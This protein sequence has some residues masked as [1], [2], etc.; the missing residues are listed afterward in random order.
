MSMIGEW[1]DSGNLYLIEASII[2]ATHNTS[3]GPFQSA[4]FVHPSLSLSNAHLSAAGPSRLNISQ[5]GPSSAGRSGGSTTI[6][7]NTLNPTFGGR[8]PTHTT[9]E[10]HVDVN[11]EV[12]DVAESLQGRDTE[13]VEP[14]PTDQSPPSSSTNLGTPSTMDI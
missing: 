13:Q 8:E 12:P 6:G 3:D 5:H 4:P 7:S 2:I 9:T 10:T 14:I 1:L 11:M